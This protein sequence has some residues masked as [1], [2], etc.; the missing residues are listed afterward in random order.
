MAAR[1]ITRQT[2]KY[3]HTTRIHKSLHWLTILI[4]IQFNIRLILFKI[5][6]GHV[7]S[8]VNDLLKPIVL[9]RSLR[10]STHANFK[11][12]PGPRTNTRYGDRA[13]DVAAPKLRNS[14]T[15]RIHQSPTVELFKAQVHSKNKLL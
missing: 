1:L 14:L 9:S 11:Y 10:S 2:R 3:E 13:F 8:Y 15:I 12:A 6:H 4:C 7:P 5:K